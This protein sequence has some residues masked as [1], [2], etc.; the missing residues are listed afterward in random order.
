MDDAQDRPAT[1]REAQGACEPRAS[2]TTNREAHSAEG[3]TNA[4]AMTA[5]DRDEARK[6]LGENAPRT[7]RPSAEEATHLQMQEDPS[8][9]DGQVG[10]RASVGTM[11]CGGA[12]LTTWTC[13]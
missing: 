9:R 4:Y 6:P 12:V 3:G 10:D 1:P 7:R 5:T 11:H 2:T 8:P 13:G